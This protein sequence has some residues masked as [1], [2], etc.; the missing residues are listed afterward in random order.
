MII[1]MKD[2][3]KVS[4]IRDTFAL[5][6]T[7][8]LTPMPHSTIRPLK[9]L[10][11]VI[12]VPLAAGSTIAQSHTFRIY[13][14]LEKVAVNS[15]ANRISCTYP[16]SEKK[17]QPTLFHTT[18]L[19]ENLRA[20]DSVEYSVPGVAHLIANTSND[21]FDT[22]VYQ[23]KTAEGQFLQFIVADRTTGNIHSRFVKSASD[24]SPYFFRRI[25]K[26]NQIAVSF[27][28]NTGSPD[29]MIV[30]LSINGAGGLPGKITAWSIEDGRVLWTLDSPYLDQ[31]LTT[32]NELIGLSQQGSSGSALTP[33]Y[34][35]HFFN[36]QDGKLIRTTTFFAGKGYRL[37]SA[38]TANRTQ[39][40]IAGTEYAG[41]SAKHGRF[42]MSMFD[43]TGN[44]LFDEVDST[45]RLSSQR[46]HTLGHVFDA[47]GNLIIIGEGWKPDATRAIAMT[48]A[49][50][51]TAVLIGA[52]P[53]VYGTID[54]K[55]T[56]LVMAKIS[57]TNG[58]VINFY[59]FPAGPWLQYSSMITD[60]SHVLIENANQLLLYDPD[61]P[62]KPPVRFT[63]FNPRQGLMITPF[64][65]I[66]ITT[67]RKKLTLER[68][69]TY[70]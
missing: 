21:L 69:A 35:L 45:D 11:T 32:E 25:R 57:S 56:S 49:S 38:A 68:I 22:F 13:N 28:D 23:C 26:T 54:H 40:M 12:L 14:S 8:F 19:D 20:T 17:A 65:P 46:M 42:Y 33:H 58:S 59:S 50:I 63:T 4:E 51:L 70:R 2:A 66:T 39:L 41:N 48:T 3:I 36:K 6:Q 44:R 10:L 15:D 34:A 9:A 7:D 29:V 27:V 53:G 24:L 61:Q 47:E 37:I 31:V 16:Y 62:G 55:I 43:L 30:R 60:G 1:G 67:G 52:T 18:Y 64:G 5:I